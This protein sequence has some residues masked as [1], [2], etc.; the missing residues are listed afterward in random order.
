MRAMWSVNCVPNLRS[1]S[2]ASRSA[3]GIGEG[4][5]TTRKA[6][7][8]DGACAAAVSTIVRTS[9]VVVVPAI[10]ALCPDASGESVAHFGRGAGGAR[11][12]PC[13]TSR[14]IGRNRTLDLGRE[15]GVTQEV[16]HHRDRQ[17]GGRRVG[18]L[19]TR[20]VG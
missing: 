20:N 12:L 11:L 7:A 17:H 2:A 13:G 1:A 19:L 6:P 5:A 3:S 16:E 9:L 10:T 4:L 15:F 8:F 18:L 14:G